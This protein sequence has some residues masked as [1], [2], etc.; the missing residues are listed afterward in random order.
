M[1]AAEKK[2]QLS[3]HQKFEHTSSREDGVTQRTILCVALTVEK[4]HEPG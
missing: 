4:F 1:A 3:F 2:M